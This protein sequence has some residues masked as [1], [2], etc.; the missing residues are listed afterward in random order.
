MPLATAKSEA[1]A[2]H[3]KLASRAR[4][5]ASRARSRSD[6]VFSKYLQVCFCRENSIEKRIIYLKASSTTSDRL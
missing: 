6:V 2:I 5:L 4:S 1:Y 3:I